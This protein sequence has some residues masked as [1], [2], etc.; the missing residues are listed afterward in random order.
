M[1]IDSKKINYLFNIPY[2]YTIF[3]TSA[4]FTKV[5]YSRLHEIKNPSICYKKFK[6][7]KYYDLHN[8]NIELMVK[9]RF[10]I[11]NII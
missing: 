6:N 7:L 2:Y 10:F 11:K 1:L 4:F 8:I 5:V 3:Q 9:I